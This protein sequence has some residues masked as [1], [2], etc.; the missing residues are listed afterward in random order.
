M[1]DVQVDVLG[2]LRVRADDRE[3]DLGGPRNRALVARLA[4][5]AGRP[6]A[7]TTLIADLWDLDVPADATNALQS[8]VSRTR[9]R[10]PVGALESTPAGY[11]LQGASVDAV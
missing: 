1:A 8:I 11:V 6:V 7:A 9:R 10:L 4:L 2:P 3:I 5:D